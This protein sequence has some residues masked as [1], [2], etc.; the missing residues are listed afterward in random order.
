[1]RK[2]EVKKATNQELV[3]ELAVTN[4]EMSVACNRNGHGSLT[5]QKKLEWL[6]EEM[7]KRDLLTKEQAEH[8]LYA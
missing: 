6:T 1:M 3:Y 8:I 7:V 2:K 5:L 4:A